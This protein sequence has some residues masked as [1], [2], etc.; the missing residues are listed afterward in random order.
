MLVD[1]LTDYE[2]NHRKGHCRSDHTI[3]R[4]RPK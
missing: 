4:K 2:L 3:L 1:G